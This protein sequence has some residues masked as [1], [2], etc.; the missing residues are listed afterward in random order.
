MYS[1][2]IT[3]AHSGETPASQPRNADAPLR[4]G[5]SAMNLPKIGD[6]WNAWYP[7]HNKI[8][9]PLEWVCRRI[10]VTDV[11]DF[12]RQPLPVDE[13]L[14]RPLLRRG[15]ILICGKDL[16]LG[17]YREFYWDATKGGELPAFRLGLYSPGESL[18]DWF[19]DDFEATRYDRQEM[20]DEVKRFSRWQA[21]HPHIDLKLGIYRS[22][23]A[24]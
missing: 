8:G 19:S 6:E 14:N 10:L 3:K 12:S 20:Y 22:E 9:V 17:K 18:I 7:T 5:A 21:E 23:M 16:M 4:Q 13:F 24:A 11:C 1:K 2:P 15:S